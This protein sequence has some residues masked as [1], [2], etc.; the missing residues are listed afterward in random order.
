MSSVRIAPCPEP[1]ESPL[2]LVHSFSCSLNA[3]SSQ[4]H[5]ISYLQNLLD[6]LTSFC[7][8]SR[9]ALFLDAPFL[10]ISSCLSSFLSHLFIFRYQDESSRTLIIANTNSINVAY[11]ITAEFKDNQS[12]EEAP[13]IVVEPSVGVLSAGKKLEL[14][15]F[16]LKILLKAD[17]Q[18]NSYSFIILCA[19]SFGDCLGKCRCRGHRRSI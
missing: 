16:L 3:L 12:Q 17:L 10:S 14:Y 7:F 4:E 5:V 1:N 8:L 6:S 19:N 9:F 2:V 13:L 11:F 15:F 18:G